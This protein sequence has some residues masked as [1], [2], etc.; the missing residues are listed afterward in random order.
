MHCSN[1]KILRKHISILN[2]D[3]VSPWYIHD[4]YMVLLEEVGMHLCNMAFHGT[5]AFV[6][7]SHVLLQDRIYQVYTRYILGIYR[8]KVRCEPS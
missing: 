4:I 8:A 1:Q 7:K 5:N 2:P 6:P 3:N